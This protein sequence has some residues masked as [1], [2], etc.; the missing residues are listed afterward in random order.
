MSVVTIGEIE[1]EITQ[2]R[3]SNHEFV[4]E[5]ESWLDWVLSW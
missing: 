5:L 4:S 1:R 3:Q 2:Q